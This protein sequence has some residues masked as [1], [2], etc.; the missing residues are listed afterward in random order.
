MKTGP[1]PMFRTAETAALPALSLAQTRPLAEVAGDDF[2]T[3]A[4][5]RYPTLDS[6]PEGLGPKLGLGLAV[7]VLVVLAII[8]VA[9]VGGR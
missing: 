1:Q 5:G 3:R 6:P 8:V 2:D 9:C 4:T 7:D